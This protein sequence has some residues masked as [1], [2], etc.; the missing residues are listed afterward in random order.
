M[1]V[2]PQDAHEYIVVDVVKAPFD[3]AFDEPRRAVE[4]LLDLSECGMTATFRPKAVR[5]VPKA[6]FV[7]G[8]Q[9][10]ADDFLHQFLRAIRDAQWSFAAALLRDRGTA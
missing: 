4:C 3:I 5:T 9:H 1:N 7:V 2:T 8:F 6:G 10:H